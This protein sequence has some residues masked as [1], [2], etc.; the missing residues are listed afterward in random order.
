VY[1]RQHALGFNDCPGVCLVGN[2]P[3]FTEAQL[4]S[5]RR[6]VNEI[7]RRYGIPVKNVLGHDE[8]PLC[9]K[10]KVCPNMDMDEFRASLERG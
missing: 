5:A 7:R 4:A 8:T 2:G 3:T 9:E 6:L 1:K 10:G